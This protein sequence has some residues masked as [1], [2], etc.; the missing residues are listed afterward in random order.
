MGLSKY[1]AVLHLLG[2]CL[3]IFL[4]ARQ[5]GWKDYQKA[6]VIACAFFVSLRSVVLPF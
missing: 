2:F 1:A 5:S 3:G 6:I 4:L